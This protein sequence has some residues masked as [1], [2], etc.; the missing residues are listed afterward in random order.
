MIDRVARGETRPETKVRGGEAVARLHAAKLAAPSMLD[1]EATARK[2][3]K[4]ALRE[5]LAAPPDPDVQL[6]EMI[7]WALKIMNMVEMQIH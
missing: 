2:Y 7:G 4:Q 3:G 5:Y 6:D 1:F